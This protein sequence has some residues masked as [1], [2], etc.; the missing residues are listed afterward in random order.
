MEGV[1][2]RQRTECSGGT[3][4]IV[5]L[6]GIG[7][8]D[9]EYGWLE[10]LNRGLVQA[11][12][13]PIDR[14]QVI[15]P[16]YSSYLKTEGRGGKLPPLSYKPPKDEATAR[17]E[18][19]RR[20]AGV[21]R[22]LKIQHGVRTF[23]FNLIPDGLW[24]AAPGMVFDNLP[25]MDLEQVRR[26]VR[27]E[28][29]RAAV[30]NHILDFLPTYGDIILIAHSLG[31]VVAIDLLDH[32]PPNLHV[33]RFI[34]IGSPGNIKALHEGSERLLKKFPYGRV[35]DWSNFLNIL[36][37]VTG[38]RGLANTFPG[39]QDFRLN[40][41]SG[42]GAGTYLGDPAISSLIADVLYPSKDIVRASADV[43][44]R[45]SDAE[46]STLLLQH[47]AEAVAQNIK[48]A[49]QAERYRATLKLL[50]DDLG[51]QLEH[52]AASG[53][54]LSSEMVDLIN[55]KLARLPH[56]WELHEAIAEL[57][58]LALTNP[59]SPYEINPGDAPKKALEDIAVELGFRRQIGTTVATAINDV[60]AR[61]G[62]K[63]GVP[64]GRV[65]TAA[66]GVALLAAGPVGLAVAAPAGAFGAAAITGGLAAFGPGGMVGGLTMLGSLAGAGA[67]TTAAAVASGGGPEASGP[68]LEKL[69]MR[70]SIEYARKLLDLPFDTTLWYQLTDF[71]CQVSAII[72]RLKAFNDAKSPKLAQL[73]AAQAAL[74]SLLRFMIEKGL[75][76]EAITD[77][78]PK[79]LQA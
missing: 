4:K 23:G 39:A 22:L 3:V 46:A 2:A 49:E 61:V 1:A 44:V 26:Y 68:N 9:P 51:A 10:G 30:M 38:G 24:E 70:V 76:P 36:D 6:H 32:L 13:E 12:H 31:S 74:N 43:A 33:R 17:R 66:A 8:G 77:G 62:N 18:F 79:A 15:T 42:H 75:S 67:A 48:D 7:N 53:Q 35:D 5:F 37:V 16:R 27:D 40:S 55:G 52:Q 11:N 45:M 73:E 71:E 34:T 72:N 20:Q 78:E 47:F 19:E 59:V 29:V 64:W 69:M 41:I 25:I 57:V 63:G 14:E 28:K 65:L 60:Q 50:R 58:V 21:Q 54:L 56:R